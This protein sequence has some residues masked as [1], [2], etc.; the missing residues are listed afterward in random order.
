MSGWPPITEPLLRERLAMDDGTFAAFIR[1][2]LCAL[3]PRRFTPE[4]LA[5]A[6]GYP[7]ERPERSY[8]LT[9][10]EVEVLDAMA[11]GRRAALLAARAAGPDGAPRF[12]LLAFGSNGA[13]AT[14]E[15]KLAHLP[16]A[17]RRVLVLAG[18]LRDFD[19]GAAA[20]PTGYGALPAT[21]FASPGTAVRAAVLWVSAAQVTQLCWTELT[22]RL[23]RLQDIAF[24]PDQPTAPVEDVLTYASRWGVFC[25]DGHPLALAA[26]PAAGRTAPALRQE[27]LL[28]RAARLGLGEG[29]EAATL[30]RA[31]FEDMGAFS[32]RAGAA[33]QA[34]GRPLVSPAWTAWP[35]GESCTA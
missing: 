34:A 14:L 17:E 29:A 23:G 4:V 26:I 24:E 22:Y 32:A 33:L 15:R 7:W 5:T 27:E 18:Q 30:V 25:P 35:A 10:S 3:P 21:L 31:V 20:H 28:D 12:P 11:P 1:A 19:V 16:A 6:L 9:G 8:L 13:P 2:T